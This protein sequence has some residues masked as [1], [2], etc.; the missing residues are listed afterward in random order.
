MSALVSLVSESA[1]CRKRIKL[2]APVA[3]I[4]ATL[5]QEEAGQRAPIRKEMDGDGMQLDEEGEPA[6]VVS[7]GVGAAGGVLGSGGS[8]SSSS[9]VGTASASSRD[10]H[11][12][13]KRDTFSQI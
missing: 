10:N 6:N 13:F 2:K 3:D 4:F 8:S 7:A 1:E 9:R 11:N 5:A 12:F